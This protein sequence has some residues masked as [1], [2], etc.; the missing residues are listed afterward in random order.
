[1]APADPIEAAVKK[2]ASVDSWN[3]RVALI[4]EIP[5]E[6]G[7]ALHQA[8]YAAVAKAIYVSELAPDFAYIHW[9]DEY[10]LGPIEDAY[11]RAFD[12]T[13]GFTAV[14]A[15]D[16]AQVIQKEPSTVRIFRL[17]LGLTTQEFAASTVI[18]AAQLE[19]QAISNR[20]IKSMECGRAVGAKN[21]QVAAAVIDK[22]MKGEL[23]GEHVGEVRSKIMKPDTADGGIPCAR[24]L[25][26]MCR[27][28]YFCIRVTT[29][30]HFGSYWM[31]H[32]ANA[33]I[34]WNRLSRSYSLRK[35]YCSFVRGQAINPRSRKSSV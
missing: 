15:R 31:L 7:K 32:Q 28:P 29:A 26:T 22:A 25:Q 27:Y 18:T 14:E 34:Y 17:I 35:E 10:E 30:V 4:R 13:K 2:I 1:V 3:K 8:V 12:L 5:E 16:L 20:A 24:L 11:Q 9:R 21:A 6:F 33:V 19:G 23:F